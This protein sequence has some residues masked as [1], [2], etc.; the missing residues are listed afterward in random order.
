[1][2]MN[3]QAICPRFLTLPLVNPF[4]K[5]PLLGVLSL[6]ARDIV[7]FTFLQLIVHAPIVL[8]LLWFFAGTLAY[9]P[10][11]AP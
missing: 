2:A 3:R 5:L 7:G 1:M 4:W 10:P 6:K 9:V 11:V 8:F